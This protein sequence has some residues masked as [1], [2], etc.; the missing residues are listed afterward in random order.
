MKY[1][2]SCGAA[3]AVFCAAAI[4]KVFCDLTLELPRLHNGALLAALLGG[5][6]AAPIVRAMTS[7]A[8]SPSFRVSCALLAPLAALEAS[9]SIRTLA[10]AAS[11]LAFDRVPIALLTLPIC[12]VLLRVLLLEGDAI[13]A[14]ARVWLKVFPLFMVLILALQLPHLEPDWL[15]PVLGNGWAAVLT[16]AVRVAATLCL[17]GALWLCAGVEKMPSKPHILVLAAASVAAGLTALQLMMTPTT[18]SG[19]LT[20]VYLLDALLTNGR[21]PIILQLPM[22]IV[23][24]IGMLNLLTAEAFL[25]ASL[26]GQCFPRLDRRPAALIA[27]VFVI[28]LSVIRVPGLDDPARLGQIELAVAALTAVAAGLRHW[29][30]RHTCA[31]KG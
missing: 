19:E 28:I 14:S 3:S 9:R 12:L 29:G 26:L 20:R 30:G 4:A 16:G 2:I 8:R 25:A 31:Q 21:A 6:F 7:A 1:A 17:L 11:F 13:G 27:L 15:F 24:F 22:V 5:A 10:H 23:W 18:V